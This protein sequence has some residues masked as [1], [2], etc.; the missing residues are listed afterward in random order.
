METPFDS[1][2]PRDRVGQYT[3]VSW[4]RGQRTQLAAFDGDLT[5]DVAAA[6]GTRQTRRNFSAP[7]SL[8]ELGHLLWLACRTFTSRPSGMGF[9]LENRPHPSS[10]GIHPIHLVLQRSDGGALERYNT[11]DH[12]LEELPGSELLAS[13]LR[14]AADTAVATQA[15]TLIALVAEPGKT[16]AKYTHSASL[17]MRDAG[18][19]LGYLSLCSEV[20][21]LNFCPLGM[22]GD[23]YLQ[24]LDEQGKLRGVGLA[25]IGA[26]SK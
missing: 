16:A 15:S 14:A 9:D 17:V 7:I 19:I 20:L 11:R 1:P 21:G 5:V 26:R 13:R 24:S 8:D 18:V 10:G 23:G 6:L 2:S 12:S 4:P 25:L 3:E 22:T